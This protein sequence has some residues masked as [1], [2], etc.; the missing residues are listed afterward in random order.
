[1]TIIDQFSDPSFKPVI[2]LMQA[3]PEYRELT[4]HAS[5]D[6]GERD[7]LP[8]SAFAWPEERLF[9]IDTRDNAVLSKLFMEKQAAYIP[10]VVKQR[11]DNALRI[12]GVNP[13]SIKIR[14]KKASTALVRYVY[15]EEKKL[16]VR[17]AQ[18]YKVASDLLTSNLRR[19]DPRTRTYTAVRLVKIG[20]ELGEY[21]PEWAL[22][23]SGM[24]VCDKGRLKETIEV[25]TAVAPNMQLKYAYNKLLDGIQQLPDLFDDF[26]ELTKFAAALEELDMLAGLVPFYSRGLP[27]PMLSV[28]NTTKVASDL[29]QLNGTTVPLETLLRV[30]V[31]V[32][33]TIFGDEIVPEI[34]TNGDLDPEKL[35][36]VL[37]TMPADLIRIFLQQVGNG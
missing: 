36:A 21:P 18:D 37:P 30:P 31:D 26:S 22:Q 34:T 33:A 19:M 10:E 25:R 24:T 35:I 6:Y 14:E 1:V 12:Y 32:Y 3:N 8:D 28:F 11:C 17:N 15:P 9:R 5:L 16:P 27:D 23:Y 2:Q 4:K 20:S 29:V 7:Q 13:D